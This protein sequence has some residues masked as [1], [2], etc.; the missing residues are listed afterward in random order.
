MLGIKAEDYLNAHIE[1]EEAYSGNISQEI[2]HEHMKTIFQDRSIDPSVLDLELHPQQ[3]AY[4]VSDELQAV[5]ALMRY[6][7]G[8][9]ETVFS[10]SHVFLG[11]LST[12]SRAA[13]A[14]C[15]SIQVFPSTQ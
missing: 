5:D 13:F 6:R 10:R 12:E 7:G 2:P 1:V 3:C 8:K 4:F 9:L 14:I 11:R 15:C